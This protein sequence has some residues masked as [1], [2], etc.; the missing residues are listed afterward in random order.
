QTLEGQD[1][2]CI[3]RQL[4]E[5]HVRNRGVRQQT[6]HICLL[7]CTPGTVEDTNQTQNDREAC[8]LCRS[9]REEWN[10]KT[11]QTVSCCLDQDTC[12]VYQTRCRCLP[13]CILYP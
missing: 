8:K 4:Y 12:K 11:K 1:I 13:M 9:C 6:F 7:E 2:T 10:H 5:A 3:N